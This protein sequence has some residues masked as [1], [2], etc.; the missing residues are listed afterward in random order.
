MGCVGSRAKLSKHDM[1]FL[2]ENTEFTKQQIKSWYSGFIVD[3]PSG[4]L[5]KAKFI[6]VYQ[7]LFPQGNAQKFCGHIFRQ[8][9]FSWK[10]SSSIMNRK[11]L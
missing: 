6:E 1:N 10:L 8:V 5:S 9:L 4:E 11:Y 2:T 7:Q 3:C